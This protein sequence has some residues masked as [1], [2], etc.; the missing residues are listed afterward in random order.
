LL[1]RFVKGLGQYQDIQEYIEYVWND[2]KLY[3]EDPIIRIYDTGL[4]YTET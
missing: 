2:P 1:I 3:E 4:G